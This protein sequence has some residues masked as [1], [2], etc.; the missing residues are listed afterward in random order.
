MAANPP[1]NSDT[2]N[3]ARTR[4]VDS[5]APL[6][7]APGTL[8]GRYR[9]EAVLGQGGF[10]ITYRAVDTVLHR[11]VA[12]KEYLPSD[13]AVRI[14]GTTVI[15][16]SRTDA[17]DY[18]WGLKRFLDEAKTLAQHEA[19]PNVVRVYDFVEANGTAYMVMALIEGQNLS[20]I[21]RQRGTLSE[22]ELRGIVL[23]LLDGLEQ[24]HEAGLIHRDIKPANIILRGGRTPTLIDFGAAR[25]GLGRKSRSVTSILT[26][27]YAPFEQYGS[28]GDQGPW[29]DIYA[30]AATLYHGIAGKAPPDSVDRIRRDPMVPAVQAGA[31]K[32]SEDFLAA[33][34]AGLRVDERE[35]PQNAAAWRA[36]FGAAP[37][38]IVPPLS[39]PATIPPPVQPVPPSPL[40]QPAS[41]LR[42][43]IEPPPPPS[44]FAAPPAARA[45][46][47]MLMAAGAVVLLI[48]GGVA[49]ALTMGGSPKPVAAKPDRAALQ[50]AEAEKK[51]ADE[52]EKK[53]AEEA[54]SRQK[55]EAQVAETEARRKAEEETRRK[56]AEAA[57]LK[58][59]TEAREQAEA[60]HRRRIEEK[61]RKKVEA[62]YRA[63][64]EEEARRRQAEEETRRQAEEEARRKA[65]EQARLKAEAEAREQAEAEHRRRIEE[66]AR[67]KV[68]AEYQARAEEEARKRRAEE[69]TR[70][71]TEEARKKAEDEAR[72]KAEDEARK[73]AEQQK[74]AGTQVAAAAPQARQQAAIAPPPVDP[75]AYV[76]Q[77]WPTALRPQIEAALTRR[78]V[79]TD[80][81]SGTPMRFDQIYSY[82]V[83][84]ISAEQIVLSVTYRNVRAVP[85]AGNMTGTSAD[86]AET[87]TFL[88]QPPG[89][90]LAGLK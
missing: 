22:Q 73:R 55:L 5:G 21:L 44:I 67:K 57:K 78:G 6:A 80:T 70:R 90:P 27:G 7:L 58:A 16:R 34:D 50:L 38:G 32:Y 61:T 42:P 59:E 89:F 40:S 18:D 71:K 76:A 28:A 35:R 4:V 36:L 23:P 9:I 56:A 54:A 66:D 1:S 47:K 51:R 31:G 63:K 29:T 12:V 77:H 53:L 52:I 48:A 20:A 43:S 26:P 62:E 39:Q 37:A 15:P 33:I 41:S 85:G 3:N 64:A 13:V 84:R 2:D 60:E 86:V 79:I 24:L 46:R 8:L 74:A 25:E 49:V 68:E 87:A 81:V 19:V 11:A 14:D 10:G 30:L 82:R 45:S 83:V 65:A 17:A 88:N 72:K 75:E 69:E